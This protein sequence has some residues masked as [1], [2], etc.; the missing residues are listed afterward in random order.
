MRS[1][2]T[3]VTA[4]VALVMLGCGGGDAVSPAQAAFEEAE[5]VRVGQSAFLQLRPGTQSPLQ[6]RLLARLTDGTWVENGLTI[7]PRRLDALCKT[8]TFS[9]E[10]FVRVCKELGR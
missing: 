9:T 6:R 5:L 2:A 7:P 10:A 1:L 4:T 8:H 3:V